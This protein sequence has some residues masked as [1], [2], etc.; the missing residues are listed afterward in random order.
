MIKQ[1][2]FAALF[3]IGVFCALFCG[4][5]GLESDFWRMLFSV[6]LGAAALGIAGLVK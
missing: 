3:T 5:M 6:G 2:I 1:I 4:F